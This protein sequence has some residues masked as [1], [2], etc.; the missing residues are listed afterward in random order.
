MGR[1]LGLRVK[2]C[3]P[4]VDQPVGWP[5]SLPPSQHLFCFLLCVHP[6]HIHWHPHHCLKK[7][8]LPRHGTSH[9]SPPP[10]WANDALGATGPNVPQ[11]QQPAKCTSLSVIPDEPQCSLPRPSSSGSSLGLQRGPMVSWRH[12]PCWQHP[13]PM[14][15]TSTSWT[16]CLLH[17]CC[18]VPVALSSLKQAASA[19]C[20]CQHWAL[21]PQP[22][23]HLPPLPSHPLI[24]QPGPN[25]DA[26]HS[27]DNAPNSQDAFASLLSHLG[28]AKDV[29]APPQPVTPKTQMPPLSSL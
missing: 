14:G 20:P 25:R 5:L 23:N 9:V 7:P 12:L 4:C 15:H 19:E 1:I 17:P 6:W 16:Q 3:T 24:L 29:D 26:A 21:L 2:P 22:T 28:D 10:N 8:L 11:N 27:D 13:F 18:T